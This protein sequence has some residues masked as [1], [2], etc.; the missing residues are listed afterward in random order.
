MKQTE[1]APTARLE[2]LAEEMRIRSA[3][4][5][6]AE[7]VA[8]DDDDDAMATADAAGLLNITLNSTSEYC[9]TL[10]DIPTYGQ[11]GNRD[12]DPDELL[13]FERELKEQRRQQHLEDEQKATGWE[14]V[15]IDSKPVEIKDEDVNVLDEEPVAAA[16]I[17]AALELAKKKGYLEASGEKDAGVTRMSHL[18][19]QRYTI[20]ER[21]SYDIEDKHA[22]RDRYAGPV[23]DFREKSSY[24]P[25][26]RLTYIDDSGRHL[27]QKEA[28]RFLSHKFHGKV[29]GK[30]KTEKRAKK[31]E[32]EL[33]MRKMSSTD[34]PLNTLSLLQDK[35]KSTQS[36][37]IVLS[38]SGKGVNV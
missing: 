31:V 19:A 36:A 25:D 38:G 8:D 27:N 3:D 16:G 35:Q 18:Q 1:R 20:E 15:Q 13:D 4:A 11:A 23:T 6:A 2:Q 14:E 33:L 28:F 29:S 34:T 7:A 17:A 32:D 9:R 30:M 26:V 37:F 21:S 24:R 22:R 12:D 10:G 5:A